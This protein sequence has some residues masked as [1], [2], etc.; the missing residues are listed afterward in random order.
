MFYAFD[1]E[2]PRSTTQAAPLQVDLPLNEG[3]ISRVGIGYPDGCGGLAQLQLL[4][5]ERQVFPTNPNS[6]FQWNGEAIWWDEYLPLVDTPFSLKANAWNTDDTTQ[7]TITVWV[8][9]VP[10][11]VYWR[12]APSKALDRQLRRAFGLPSL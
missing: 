6:H 11:D 2:I 5:F 7:H 10:F 4:R 9:V 8:S 3:I 12:L 1:L